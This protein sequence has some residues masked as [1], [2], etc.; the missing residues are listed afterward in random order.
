MKHM[1]YFRVLEAFEQATCC[2]LCELERAAVRQDLDNV[3][4]EFVNDPGVRACL[5]QSRGYCHRHA[6][7]LASLGK[8]SGVAILYEDQLHAYLKSLSEDERC[9]S[10]RRWKPDEGW[11]NHDACPACQIQLQ[12]RKHAIG[13]L[14]DGLAEPAMREAYERG[15]GVCAPHLIHVLKHARSPEQ[16]Q[17][18]LAIQRRQVEALL[19]EIREFIR[20]QDYRF[21]HEG[22]GREGDSWRRAIHRMAGEAEVF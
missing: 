17:Y 19:A 20:K 10:N 4:Y 18:L 16:R 6:H 13:V 8:G 12:Q 15:P 3:L 21:S 1:P 14:C 22:F 2:P 5:A 7:I 11:A 9:S